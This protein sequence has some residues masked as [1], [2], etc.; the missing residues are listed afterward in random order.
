MS[1]ES[2]GP[3]NVADLSIF[4]INDALRQVVD[5]IDEAKGLRG[6]AVIFDRTQVGTPTEATD[7]VNLGTASGTIVTITGAQTVFGAKTF[8]GVAVR[9]TDSA[10]HLLHSFGAI[11]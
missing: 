8:Q 7:A 2:L 9:V 5:R 11:T 3:I 10:G 4:A 6:R 1:N